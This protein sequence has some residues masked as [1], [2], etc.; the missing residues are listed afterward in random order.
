VAQIGLVSSTLRNLPRLYPSPVNRLR[1]RQR[2]A[3]AM[4]TD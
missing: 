3:C 2:F 4:H 1:L